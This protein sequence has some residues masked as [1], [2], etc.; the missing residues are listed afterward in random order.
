MIADI[1][2]GHTDGADICFLIAVIIFFVAAVVGTGKLTLGVLTGMLTPI[3]LALL[4]LGW[5]IL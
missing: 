4:A 5:L 3:G 2:H 1:A